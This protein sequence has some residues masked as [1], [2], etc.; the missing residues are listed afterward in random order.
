MFKLDSIN[1]ICGCMLGVEYEEIE[2]TSFIIVDLLIFQ[3]IYIK[4]K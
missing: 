2:D 4:Q 3:F 1:L